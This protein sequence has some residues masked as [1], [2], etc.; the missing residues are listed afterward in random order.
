MRG[1]SYVVEA[2]CCNKY[3]ESYVGDVMWRANFRGVKNGVQPMSSE[4]FILYQLN[5]ES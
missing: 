2:T 1:A 4:L 5:G 3:G